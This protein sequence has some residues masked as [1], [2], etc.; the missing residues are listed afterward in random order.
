MKKLFLTFL[1][2][3]LF[4]T[5]CQLPNDKVI[6]SPAPP[7]V[8]QLSIS[9]SQISVDRISPSYNPEDIVDTTIVVSVLVSHTNSAI[10]NIVFE[11]VSA[12]GVLLS[13]KT[14][15]NDS[16]TIPDNTAND[17]TYTGKV[18]IKFKKKNLGNYT[19]RVII[20]DTEGHVI[21]ALHAF[22]VV[23][24][25]V[26]VPQ[27]LSVNIPDTTKIPDGNDSV[28]VQ[29]SAKV[30]DAQ[31]ISD[32]KSV[33]AVVT[34][35]SGDK[36]FS[37]S[38]YDDGG[39][40]IVPPFHLTSGDAVQGDSIFSCKIIFRKKD[41]D[42]YL[43]RISAVDSSESSG[44]TLSKTISIRNQTNGKPVII[45]VVLPDTVVV[46]SGLDTAFVKISVLV[47]DP[48]GLDD[49]R[50]VTFGSYRADNS[51]VG[52]YELFDDG[53]AVLRIIYSGY[54][55]YSGDLTSD[56]GIYTITI[57]I[58]S[59]S[60]RATYRDFKFQ[61]QDRAGEISSVVTKR[62]YLQ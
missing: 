57:P 39:T 46:P 43:V 4:F 47:T 20:N 58:T 49:I 17:G 62:I 26:K 27:V 52:S 6:D 19:V 16:G 34:S 42:D 29:L 50:N 44:N 23:N 11:V 33:T 55:A 15:L 59:S 14:A 30:T 25:F 21:T 2:S 45:S 24:P 53:G 54:Q 22:S 38:L 7:V 28:I 56:D 35:K 10:Q 13:P 48:Q 18:S 41:I 12:E 51:Y 36:Q 61:A 60:V 9:P 40:T 31:G 1:L 37:V 3:L 8:E 32:I 5:G